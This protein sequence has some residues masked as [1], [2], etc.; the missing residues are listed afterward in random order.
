MYGKKAFL[1]IWKI[2][3]RSGGA[4]TTEDNWNV[5]AYPLRER[6][7]ITGFLCVENAGEYIGD[8]TLIRTLVPYILGEQKRF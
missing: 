6:G 5:L 4:E 3:R 8:V 2:T 1:S 7:R